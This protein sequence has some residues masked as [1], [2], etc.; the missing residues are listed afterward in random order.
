MGK[1][2]TRK[3]RKHKKLRKGGI[4]TKQ[5]GGAVSMEF[6]KPEVNA[7]SSNQSIEGAL[8]KQKTQ[9]EQTVELNKAMAGGGIV[10]PQ[11][12]QAGESGNKSI[13]GSISSTLKG[14]ADGEFDDDVY[15]GGRSRKKSKKRKSRKLRGGKKRKRK[16]KRKRKKRRK[17]RR[18]KGGNKKADR[19]KFAH[20]MMTNRMG[21]EF[22]RQSLTAHCM[23]D[24]TD[25]I[26]KLHTADIIKGGRRKK[27]SKRRRGGRGEPENDEIQQDPCVTSNKPNR[28]R[29]DK[30]NMRC[31][32]DLMPDHEQK[33]RDHCG[34]LW[35][36]C[37]KTAG[38]T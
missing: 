26:C 20:Q 31:L 35:M 11:M 5:Y 17:S 30:A 22:S 37:R 29:C 3:R 18:R 14:K 13:M 6:E 15:K 33:D 19:A 38:N 9:S 1:R 16:T 8:H 2:R 10:I 12:G 4:F 7:T 34:E 24:P 23:R 21:S 32:N 28:C 36:G 25:P 27:F